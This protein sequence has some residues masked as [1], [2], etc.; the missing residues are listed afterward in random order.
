M[1][2][3][4][5]RVTG[6]LSI[7]GLKA[8]TQDDRPSLGFDRPPPLRK[9]FAGF[10]ATWF[11]FTSHLSVFAI[12]HLLQFGGSIRD[13]AARVLVNESPVFAQAML[14]VGTLVRGLSLDNGLDA[15]KGR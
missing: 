6:S 1:A 8:G 7:A 4:T 2:M 11:K 9:I 12:E 10:T 3:D 14:V 13:L 15:L 5:L